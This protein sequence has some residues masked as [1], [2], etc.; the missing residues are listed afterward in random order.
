MKKISVAALV[1]LLMLLA[2]TCA[3][4]AAGLNLTD[5]YPKEGS[6]GSYPINLGIKLYFDGDVAAA[7]VR[8][9]N[10]KCFKLEGED[11]EVPVKVM[12]TDA[13]PNY[14]LVIAE[15]ADKVA[16][17]GSEKKYTLTIAGELADAA[18]NTLEEPRELSFTTRNTKGDNT[19]SMVLMG[20][21]FAAMLIFTMISTKRQI[22]KEKKKSGEVEKVNPYKKAKETGKR[23]EDIVAEE[24]KK[25]QKAAEMAAKKKESEASAKDGAKKGASKG[26]R[27]LK[28]VKRPRPIS[29]G[30]GTYLTG[31][32]A[33]AERRAKEAEERRRKGTTRPKGA[34]AKARKK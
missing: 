20:V 34:K 18:G 15:P 32:K 30:G 3:G 25:K 17:L 21:M 8:E 12:F 14:I 5:N 1:A 9:N 28:R 2:S 31:R 23:V 24:E 6:T 33:A 16:G 13:D 19:V 7:E 4:F 26:G 29:E 22:D 11:G 10:E 27:R